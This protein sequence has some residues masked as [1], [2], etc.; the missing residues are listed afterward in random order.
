MLCCNS[1][2]RLWTIF[3]VVSLQ[4]GGELRC[5]GSEWRV[6]TVSLPSEVWR[7][8]FS[9]LSSYGVDGVDLPELYVVETMLLQKGLVLWFSMLQVAMSVKEKENWTKEIYLL[10]SIWQHYSGT[11]MKVHRVNEL[12][13]SVEKV[14]LEEQ[15]WSWRDVA[16]LVQGTSSWPSRS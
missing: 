7:W 10:F 15:T 11:V 14:Q 1:L 8:R 12:V 4:R 5:C 3:S 6:D 9:R 16:E 13:N 2:D